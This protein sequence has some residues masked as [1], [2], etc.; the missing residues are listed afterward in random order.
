MCLELEEVQRS[1]RTEM[2]SEG[3]VSFSRDI[4]IYKSEQKI[5]ILGI[6]QVLRCYLD[7]KVTQKK[8]L[9][10]TQLSSKEGGFQV[11]ET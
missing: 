3:E 11:S 1:W 5:L 6:E 2:G 7:R 8:N 9:I 4:N 10:V